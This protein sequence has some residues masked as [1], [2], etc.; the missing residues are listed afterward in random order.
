MQYYILYNG[1]TIGPMSKEQLA[2]YNVG[3]DTMVSCDGGEWRPLYTYPELMETIAGRYAGANDSTKMICGLCAVLI[4]WLGLQYF[5]IGKTTGGIINILI[6][7]ATCGLWGIINLIQ[8]IMRLCMSNEE[9]ERK[10]V[11]SSSAFPIF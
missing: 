10:Y 7:L 5:L 2:A 4:G 11:H 6:S 8:G 9:W 3:K 1:Q